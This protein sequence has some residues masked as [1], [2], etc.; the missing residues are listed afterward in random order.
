MFVISVEDPSEDFARVRDYVDVLNC[1]DLPAFAKD[2]VKQGFKTAMVDE[3]KD[4]FK[5]NPK[6]ARRVYEIIRLRY[7]NVNLA[8]DYKGYRV[9]VKKRLFVPYQVCFIFERIFQTSCMSKM[10]YRRR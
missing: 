2:A 9:S 8:E 7:T 1:M 3:A 6:Q 10:F 5:M 4:K